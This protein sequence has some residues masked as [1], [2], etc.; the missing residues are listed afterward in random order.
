MRSTVVV[1]VSP[2]LAGLQALRHAVDVARE[3]DATLHAVRVWLFRPM[4]RDVTAQFERRV[5]A[6]EAKLL[7]PYTFEAA[8]GGLPRGVRIEQVVLEGMTGQSLVEHAGA[9][10]DLLVV[11]GDRRRHLFGPGPVTRYAVRRAHCPVVVVPPPALAQAQP[12]DAL[13]RDLSRDLG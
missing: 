7:V 5:H 2:S 11:G 6:A 12:V 1:G 3:R 4:W 8:M 10:A 9:E 13:L